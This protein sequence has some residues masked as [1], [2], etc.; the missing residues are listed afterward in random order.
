MFP[1]SARL[2]TSCLFLSGAFFSMP[3]SAEPQDLEPIVNAG[4]TVLEFDWPA[5]SVGTAEY[6]EGPTGATVIRFDN[7]AAVAVDVRGGSPSDVNAAYMELGYEERELDA[8]VFSGGSWYGLEAVT[9]V[10]TALKDDGI[11]DGDAFAV[12][13]NIA[14]SVGSIIFDFG[15]RRL[16]EVYPDKKLAQAAFRAAKP[17]VF[18]LGAEGA[19]RFARSG[20][21][22]EC[23]AYG[24]QGA[25]FQQ[26]GDVKIAA[27]VVANPY[28]V[29][30]D[31]DGDIAA[32][33]E[34]EGWP[35]DV[36]VADMLQSLPES[37]AADWRGPDEAGASRQ[38]TT[39]SLI[40]INQKLSPAE[41]ERFAVQVHTSM[42]RGIQPFATI[43]DG[44]V[45]YAVS[46]QEE[47]PAYW[48][49]DLGSLASEVM[50][51]AVLASVPEQPVAPEPVE[52]GT[53]SPVQL[54]SLE[55]VYEYSEFVSVEVTA[56]RDKLFAKAVGERKAY[57]IGKDEKTELLPTA[58]GDFVVPGRYPHTVRFSENG[59]MIMNPGHWAQYGKRK[60][61]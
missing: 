24:G 13:P 20:G 47:E 27:F 37:R 31:R 35:E 51:D 56:R 5:I 49:P 61:R 43:W 22:L 9:A 36:S 12:E 28:G 6:A 3:A 7:R 54:K 38:N 53:R 30:V 23:N 48:L 58:N 42:A 2:M 50:W 15:S 59:E 4:E 46:T 8:V 57:N 60:G 26:I 10:A 25:A 1:S 41:L 32:C 21:I 29:I 16:N 39:V 52:R 11:R 34:G 18:P 40:V 44:D 33:Y 55:G 19:G 14:M 45:L 17:G